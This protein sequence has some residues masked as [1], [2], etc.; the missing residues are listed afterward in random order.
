ML[1][2]MHSLGLTRLINIGLR[3]MTLVSKFLLIFFLAGYLEPAE[4]G[5]YGLVAATISYAIYPL[6]FDFYTYSTRELLK[7]DRS[8]WASLLKNQGTLHLAL[9]AVVLP[10]LLLVF[11]YEL[12]PWHLAGLFFIV[13]ILEHINQELNRLLIAI[14]MQ[15]TASWVLF[16]RSGLWGLILVLWMYYDP[17]V[18]SLQVVMIAWSIG[19]FLALTL[20]YLTFYRLRLTGWWSPIDWRWILKGLKVAIP[21]L[22]ATLALQGVLTLDRYWF[23]TLQGLEVLA[24][25]VL[26]MS[27][28]NALMTFLDA[29]VFSFTYPKLISTHHEKRH[30]EFGK[31][32]KQSLVLCA[33]LTGL[34]VIGASIAIVPLLSLLN[35]EVYIQQLSLFPWILLIASLYAFSMVP[36]YALYAQGYDKAIIYSH[37]TAF[38]LFG[39]VTWLF[40]TF[41]PEKAVLLGLVAAFSV[42]L[43]WKTWAFYRLTPKSYRSAAKAETH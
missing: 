26:F 23:E 5:L 42:L 18:R 41:L 16:L 19:G 17:T 21:L 2:S 14:S 33:I 32:L 6:G 43:I 27:M 24:A 38:L 7:Q 31:A 29:G 13:L 10:L 22:L 28:A 39:L 15:L 11:V 3:G 25:Y 30:G 34:F 35:K 40:S 4:L 9:Y 1:A 37:L 12:L 36:H 8:Q 20:A